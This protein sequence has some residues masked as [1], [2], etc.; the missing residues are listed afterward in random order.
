MAR[1]HLG[2]T[3][4]EFYALTP[5]QFHLLIDQH[6]ERVEH[7][8]LLAGTVASAVANWSMKSPKEPL[9]AADFMPSR[10]DR[11]KEKPRR[12][13]RRRVA[14]RVRAFLAAQINA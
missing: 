3:D 5:R 11:E 9:C 12:V 7:Q 13:N 1:V 2:L 14:T 6:R 8:E 4:E 10:R